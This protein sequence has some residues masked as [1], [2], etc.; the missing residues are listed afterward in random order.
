MRITLRP[1]GSVV[2][3]TTLDNSALTSWGVTMPEY[4]GRLDSD[5]SG[6][7]STSDFINFI[8]DL[9]F[10]LENTKVYNPGDGQEWVGEVESFQLGMGTVPF[11]ATAYMT[12]DG[13]QYYLSGRG[14][15]GLMITEPEQY[16]GQVL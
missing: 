4:Y 13:S 15:S 7:Y 1:A 9:G 3:G 11:S 5:I 6:S 2:L 16:H 10:H 8:Q 12:V 14:I